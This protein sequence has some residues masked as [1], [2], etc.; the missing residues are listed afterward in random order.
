MKTS[1]I[2]LLLI[3]AT[4]CCVIA[5]FSTQESTSETEAQFDEPVALK[6]GDEIMNQDSKMLYPSPAVFDVDNDGK[7]EL[8]IGTIFG[9][10]Y[11]CENSNQ[12]D[13]DPVWEAPTA[14]NSVDGE[15]LDLHNW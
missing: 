2:S 7:D 4:S 9:G 13:G 11:A 10:I 5:F 3:V 15:P 14:V 1:S 8:V 12:K 6:V